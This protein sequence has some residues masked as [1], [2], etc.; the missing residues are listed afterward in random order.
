[1]FLMNCLRLGCF[2]CRMHHHSYKVSAAHNSHISFSRRLR[3]ESHRAVQETRNS[4]VE[5]LKLSATW[6]SKHSPEVP[7][8][9]DTWLKPFDRDTLPTPS[10]L[11]PHVAMPACLGWSSRRLLSVSTRLPFFRVGEEE[12]RFRQPLA[13]RML[14]L[15]FKPCIFFDCFRLYW[16]ASMFLCHLSSFVALPQEEMF[17]VMH[18][19]GGRTASSPLTASYA[20]FALF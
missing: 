6:R 13:R 1:M 3:I 19:F 12:R 2:W 9:G 14:S 7:F 10:R 18:D 16:R 17:Y 15:Q 5:S 20:F 11:R 4:V 8:P